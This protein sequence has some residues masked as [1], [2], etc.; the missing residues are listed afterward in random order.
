MTAPTTPPPGPDAAPG[1][2]QRRAQAI[3]RYGALVWIGSVMIASGI[4]V[5]V[6]KGEAAF[7]HALE[8]S[9]GLFLQILPV[10][11]AGMV[12]AGFAKSLLPSGIV[13]RWL[14]EGSG[15]RGLVIATI[16]GT[17]TPGGPPTAFPMVMVLA[18]AGAEKGCLLAYI[19]AW[20][21]NG[22]HRI[23]IWELPLLGPDFSLY[24]FLAS[25][26]LGVIAGM[27]ARRLPLDFD[28]PESARI[29]EAKPPKAA[30]PPVPKAESGP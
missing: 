11:G 22:V 23:L 26:P 15:L 5:W 19:T 13:E 9:L 2:W 16:A 4:A 27:I 21:V 8:T 18:A 7:L 28:V 6:I 14:G 10:M 20:S 30:P 25:L 12:M 1:L 17:V 3:A 29:G 24:R